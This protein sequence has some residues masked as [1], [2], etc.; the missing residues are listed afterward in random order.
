M[1]KNPKIKTNKLTNFGA[2]NEGNIQKVESAIG[3]K[4]LPCIPKI[5]SAPTGVQNKYS[6]KKIPKNV[7]NIEKKIKDR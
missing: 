6:A 4:Y 7:T 3:I 5:I 2:L 1:L